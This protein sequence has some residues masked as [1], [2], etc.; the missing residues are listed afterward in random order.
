TATE[1]YQTVVIRKAEDSKAEVKVPSFKAVELLIGGST[2][3]FIVPTVPGEY[4][5][6]CTITGHSD[7]GMH[8]HI[9]VTE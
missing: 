1:F 6:V 7:K 8:G 5:V 3:L 9:T 4:E 2:E